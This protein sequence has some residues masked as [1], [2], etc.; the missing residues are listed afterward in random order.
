LVDSRMPD[1]ENHAVTVGF[2]NRHII[3]ETQGHGVCFCE[4]SKALNS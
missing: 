1:K 2:W 4:A 3:N